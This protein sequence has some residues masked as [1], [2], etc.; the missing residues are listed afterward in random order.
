MFTIARV[1]IKAALYCN[2]LEK[3]I[4]SEQ[5]AFGGAICALN[6]EKKLLFA[7]HE[8]YVDFMQRLQQSTAI[9]RRIFFPQPSEYLRNLIGLHNL[10]V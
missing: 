7:S 5:S 3:P 1:V 2:V 8:A 9:K 10:D 4:V 6:S